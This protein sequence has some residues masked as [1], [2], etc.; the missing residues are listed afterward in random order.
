M[1]RMRAHTAV[2]PQASNGCTQDGCVC[3]KRERPQ[4]RRCRAVHVSSCL[5]Q[6]C[7]IQACELPV[8]HT[9]P[10]VSF[11]RGSMGAC[12]DTTEQRCYICFDHTAQRPGLIVVSSW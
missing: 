6:S 7:C 12:R 3:N 5:M 9:R 11:V 8:G 10:H 1:G 4:Y 2:Q